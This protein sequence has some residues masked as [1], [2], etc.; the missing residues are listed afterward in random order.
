[1][2]SLGGGGDGIKYIPDPEPISDRDGDH[3]GSSGAK[4]G[5]GGESDD[6]S[7]GGGGWS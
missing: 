4:D 5:D 7:G 2:G 1:M 3:G 6:N